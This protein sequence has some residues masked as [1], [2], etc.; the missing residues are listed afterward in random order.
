M[1][2]YIMDFSAGSASKVTLPDEDRKSSAQRAAPLSCRSHLLASELKAV[3]CLL[4]DTVTL[5]QPFFVV[6]V[7]LP[8]NALF[9]VELGCGVGVA[10]S[11]T[12]RIETQSSSL[13]RRGPIF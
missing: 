2:G 12:R 13:R 11:V 4:G 3:Q 9:T 6:Q 10:S 5:V 7:F 1:K 8:A